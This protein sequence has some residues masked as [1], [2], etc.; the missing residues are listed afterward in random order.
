ML[1]LRDGQVRVRANFDGEVEVLV[2]AGQRIDVGQ[3]ICIIEGEHEI[4]RLCARNPSIV[5]EVLERTGTDVAKGAL[6][7]VL[8]EDGPA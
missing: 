7:A 5:V 6:L 8:K 3:V 1:P 2:R 4:E